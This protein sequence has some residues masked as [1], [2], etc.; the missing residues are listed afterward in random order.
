MSGFFKLTIRSFP[1]SEFTDC[2]VFRFLNFPNSAFPDFW[3]SQFLDFRISGSNSP[4]YT[5][6]HNFLCAKT[7]HV[8]IL[9]HSMCMHRDVFLVQ[10][11][12]PSPAPPPLS[13]GRS[14]APHVRWLFKAGREASGAGTT[15]WR[16]EGVMALGERIPARARLH[17]G[18]ESAM[19][20][21]PSNRKKTQALLLPLAHYPPDAK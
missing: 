21:C 5:L 19:G 8:W 4:P 15:S 2:C 13:L 10:I 6:H 3:C 14:A 18:L 9:S 12:C 1:N 7:I 17:T 11:S 20:R 16:H